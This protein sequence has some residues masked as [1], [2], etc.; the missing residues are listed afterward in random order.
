MHCCC[1]LFSFG[2]QTE[3]RIDTDLQSC[4][5]GCLGIY[6]YYLTLYL[7]NLVLI[8]AYAGIGREVTM[9]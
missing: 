4:C 5:L 3:T 2:A 1:L 8:T 7:T 6:Y 9:Q